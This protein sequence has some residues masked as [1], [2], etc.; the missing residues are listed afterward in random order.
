MQP[1]ST[2]LSQLVMKPSDFEPNVSHFNVGSGGNFCDNDSA[3]WE[4]VRKATD[5][6]ARLGIP[7][8]D[9]VRMQLANT[10]YARFDEGRAAGL[11]DEKYANVVWP[12]FKTASGSSS[13]GASTPTPA[14]DSSKSGEGNASPLGPSI[15]VQ[16]SRDGVTDSVLIFVDG[17]LTAQ[18]MLR[19]A[20]TNHELGSSF[21]FDSL[22]VD[23]YA[24]LTCKV[25]AKSDGNRIRIGPSMVLNALVG[26]CGT[27]LDF[28]FS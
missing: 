22:L 11:L 2:S 9:S 14:K 12:V 26:V 3:Y 25:R 1:G 6:A 13:S 28:Q 19:E 18:G 20:A 21:L 16:L 10:M 4:V 27:P 24:K 15:F 8:C 23:D 5:Y 17:T 7:P